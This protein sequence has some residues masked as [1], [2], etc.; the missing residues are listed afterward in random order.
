LRPQALPPHCNRAKSQFPAATAGQALALEVNL[1]RYM[2]C[3]ASAYTSGVAGV[4][5]AA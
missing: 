4:Q 3:R 5:I 2:T 1:E